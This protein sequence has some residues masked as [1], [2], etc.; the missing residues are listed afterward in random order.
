VVSLSSPRSRRG[1]GKAEKALAFSGAARRANGSADAGQTDAR[2][3]QIRFGGLLTIEFDALP[4]ETADLGS[5]PRWLDIQILL[6]SFI[7]TKITV[8]HFATLFGSRD[9]VSVITE[10]TA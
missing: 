5:K 10:Q 1:C 6:S 9:A 7:F 4:D 2:R 3:L 8:H